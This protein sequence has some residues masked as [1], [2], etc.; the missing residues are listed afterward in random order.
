MDVG[1]PPSLAAARETREESGFEVRI[2]KLAALYDC[3]LHGHPPTAFHT[4][5][6]FFLAEL[7]AG[8]AQ[9][10]IETSDAQ[11]FAETDLP[12]LS[13]SRVTPGQIAHMFAHARNPSLP[14]SFD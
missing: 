6:V 13:L 11:F 2:T 10:S 1:E 7:C 4:Y 8:S 3:D 14:A 9:P 12:P 5:K